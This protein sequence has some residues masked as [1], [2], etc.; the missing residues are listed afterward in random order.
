MTSRARPYPTADSIVAPM[1]SR[2]LPHAVRQPCF[3]GL[4][5]FC[6]G[7]TESEWARCL[8]SRGYLRAL[9]Y[10]SMSLM[11]LKYWSAPPNCLARLAAH[12]VRSDRIQFARRDSSS[13]P[14][15]VTPFFRSPRTTESTGNRRAQAYRPSPK[16]RHA[17]VCVA[18]SKCR[19][20]HAPL[21]DRLHVAGNYVV[22]PRA[23]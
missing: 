9:R 11:R 13:G 20:H 2:R 4:Q 5:K 18:G 1:T 17:Q 14:K 23:S 8:R 15:K 21:D 22:P 12:H 7:M 19:S 3:A 10:C 6:D 16:L